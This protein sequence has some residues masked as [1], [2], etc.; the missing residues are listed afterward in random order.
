MTAVGLAVFKGH[1]AIVEVLINAG[2]DV[3]SANEASTTQRKT[4][5]VLAH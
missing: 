3:N 2:A 5:K 1:M 4:G